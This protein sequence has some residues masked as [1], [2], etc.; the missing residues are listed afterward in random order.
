MGKALPRPLRQVVLGGRNTET[1]K[2]LAFLAEAR[3]EPLPGGADARGSSEV[4]RT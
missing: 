4:H 2:R 3:S 1:L